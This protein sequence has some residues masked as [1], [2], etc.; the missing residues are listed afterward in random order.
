MTV[1]PYASQVGSEESLVMR[2]NH[3][4]EIATAYAPHITT[5]QRVEENVQLSSEATSKQ[6]HTI[7]G[8]TETCHL[9]VISNREKYVL[10]LLWSCGTA[11]RV[12]RTSMC[13]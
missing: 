10:S 7:R 9:R 1:I 13:L 12:F 4:E 8:S 5:A 6:E 11:V 3:V 2:V